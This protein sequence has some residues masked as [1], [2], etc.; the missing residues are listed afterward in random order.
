MGETGRN[1]MKKV[2]TI[3]DYEIIDMHMQVRFQLSQKG[4]WVFHIY[5]IYLIFASLFAYW[6]SI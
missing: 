2:A 5:N 3:P 4:L 6:R 1:S